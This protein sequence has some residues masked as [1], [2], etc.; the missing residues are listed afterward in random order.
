MMS[1]GDTMNV[2][3]NLIHL[4]KYVP[5][6]KFW[7][8]N[9]MKP[10]LIDPILDLGCHIGDTFYYMKFHGDIVGI[11]VHRDYF[12]T[13]RKRNIYRELVHMDLN[14]LS[15]NYGWFGCVTCFFVLE[16]LSKHEGC[17]LMDKMRH[18]GKQNVIMVP[19]GFR[20]Q[21]CVDGNPFQRH[22]SGWM[23][24]DL[25][26]QGFHVYPCRAFSVQRFPGYKIMIGV[27]TNE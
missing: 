10:F 18:L 12:A 7:M 22:R 21:E 3:R 23:P 1:G 24:S 16:H 15:S 2:L 13:C 20:T 19:H 11:D 6:S 14:E 25:I 17:V 4:T 26:E 8:L 27:R 9:K 5:H